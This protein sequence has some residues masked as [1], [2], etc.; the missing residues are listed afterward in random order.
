MSDLQRIGEGLDEVLRRLGLPAADALERLVGEW[1]ALAGEPWAGRSRPA[2]LQQGELLV[3][4]ADGVAASLLRYECGALIER[5]ATGLGGR[6]VDSVRL[7]VEARQK[8]L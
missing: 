2:G 7:R 6:F 5:L 3:E 1:P 8:G 4:V